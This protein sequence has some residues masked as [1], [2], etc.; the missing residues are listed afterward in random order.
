MMDAI[1]SYAPGFIFTTAIP[2]AVAA[3][4]LASVK[5]LKQ[6]NAERTKHQVLPFPALLSLYRAATAAASDAIA[7]LLARCHRNALPT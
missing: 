4:A 7:H 5:Y 6:S 3:G 1:R 2:P